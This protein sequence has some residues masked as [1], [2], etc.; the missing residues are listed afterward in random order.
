MRIVGNKAISTTELKAEMI[1]QEGNFFSFLTSS[2][3]FRE[4]VFQRDLLCGAG[5]GH[6]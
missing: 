3:T 5:A 2:G 6:V 4:D 1:T